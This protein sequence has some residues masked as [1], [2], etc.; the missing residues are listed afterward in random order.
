MYAPHAVEERL[1]M[2]TLEALRHR[3]YVEGSDDDYA[4]SGLTS[5]DCAFN[6]FGEVPADLD[7]LEATFR[8]LS[9][10]RRLMEERFQL[11]DASAECRWHCCQ[12]FYQL[13]L[14]L[15]AKGVF[16]GKNSVRFR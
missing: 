10:R 12:C 16:V 9:V 11:R 1:A 3:E 6:R 4:T 7:N 14:Q 15:L 2:G 8:T 5:A 13:R